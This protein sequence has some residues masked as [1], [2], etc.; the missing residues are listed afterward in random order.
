MKRILII[1]FYFTFQNQLNAQINTGY[2][3]GFLA[4]DCDSSSTDQ[5]YLDS[6][7]S[8]LRY[9]YSFEESKK[10]RFTI[11]MARNQCDI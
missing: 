11:G 6:L 3:Y 8:F 7:D 10:V 1:L 2:M 4:Y 5:L 9:Y